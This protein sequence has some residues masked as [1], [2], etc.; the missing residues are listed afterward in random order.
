MIDNHF[1]SVFTVG[2]FCWYKHIF[3]TVLKSQKL[4][5]S[6]KYTVYLYALAHNPVFHKPT[7]P[8]VVCE[9]MVIL[10]DPPPWQ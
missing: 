9:L 10:Q 4:E 2:L 7:S 5:L 1:S 6:K 3:Y 8:A